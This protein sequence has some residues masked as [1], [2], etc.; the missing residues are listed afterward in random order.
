MKTH[1]FIQSYRS[2]NIQ[3]EHCIGLVTMIY[4]MRVPMSGHQVSKAHTING[5]VELNGGTPN[6][7]TN[8]YSN[9]EGT[10]EWNDHLVSTSHPMHVRNASNRRLTR[11]ITD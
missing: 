7:C 6:D 9:A 8:I 4:L 11:S 10:F 5:I 3:S 1:L 2:I